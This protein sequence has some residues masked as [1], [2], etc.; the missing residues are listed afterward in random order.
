MNVIVSIVFNFGEIELAN[1]TPYVLLSNSSAAVKKIVGNLERQNLKE[2]KKIKK[3][4]QVYVGLV[5][6]KEKVHVFL[7]LRG[8][9]LG[10]FKR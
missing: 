5:D 4:L 3:K 10:I 7:A 6:L 8:S 2:I 1:A 9:I